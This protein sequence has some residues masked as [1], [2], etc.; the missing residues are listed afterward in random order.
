[1]H[2]A[3]GTFSTYDNGGLLYQMLGV[4]ADNST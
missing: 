4:K 3:S 2:S 1:M